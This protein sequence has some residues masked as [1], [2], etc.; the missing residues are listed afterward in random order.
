MRCSNTIQGFLSFLQ[1]PMFDGKT[2]HW[3]H[4]SCFFQKQR[5]KCV[6]DIAHFEQL[7]WE[8]QEKIRKQCVSPDAE[9]ELLKNELCSFIWLVRGRVLF[10]LLRSSKKVLCYMYNSRGLP[11]FTPLCSFSHLFRMFL[12]LKTVQVLQCPHQIHL[13]LLEMRRKER[14]AQ[15]RN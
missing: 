4:Y 15:T 2:P 8:D 9:G 12:F 7:R 5:V 6:G 14:M 13:Q 1:S 3:Y 11:Y 10:L